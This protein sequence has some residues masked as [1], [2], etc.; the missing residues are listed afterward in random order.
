MSTT[1]DAQD[2]Q[3]WRLVDA[4]KAAATLGISP[5]HLR[6]LTQC[7]Q[8]PAMRLG[9]RVM[10]DLEVLK[11]WARERMGVPTGQSKG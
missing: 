11:A 8:V 7:G 9:K 3:G 1:D 4:I 10:Y 6:T 5:R 2:G